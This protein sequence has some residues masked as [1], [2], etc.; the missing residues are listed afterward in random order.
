MG[1]LVSLCKRRG[2]VFQSSEIYGGLTGFWDYGPQGAILKKKISDHWWESLVYRR[3]DIVGLD[4]SIIAHPQVWEA[5]G[6]VECFHDLMVDCKQCKKRFRTDQF[7]GDKCPECG[8]ELTPP[9]QF[10]LMF[11]THIGPS[12][13]SQSLSY[14]RPETAQS[15]FINF[16]NILASTRLKIPFGVAQMGKAFR[17]EVTPRNFIFRSRE[18]DQMEMEYFINARESKKWFDYW[19]QERFNWYI[20]LGIKKE[21]LRLRPHSKDELAHYARECIDIE[22]NF[23]FGWQELEGIADRGDFDLKQHIN[24]SKKDLTYYDDEAK[25]RFIPAVIETSAGV[26]RTF[27]T[28]MADAFHVEELENG[29]ER[30]LLS[31]KPKLAPVEVA[32]FPLVKKLREPTIKLE[33]ELKKEFKTFY[34]EKGAI[35]RLYRRQDE[36]GTPY[37]VTFDFQSLKDNAVTVRD[38]DTMLQDRVPIDKLKDYL[39][40]HLK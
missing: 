39:G 3:D 15:I 37:C 18:F 27:L 19:V 36:I 17:N 23:P 12:S 28:V 8:G 11:Q 4:S 24:F 9:R 32:V 2:F 10:N 38:R 14:L 16:K 40:E 5:S 22:Y 13:D 25:E 29:E 35:G 21:N 20:E 34:D 1:E 26:D 7:S 6:H 31:L 30:N 33:R